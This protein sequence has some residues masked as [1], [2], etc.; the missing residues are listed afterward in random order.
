MEAWMDK[1]SPRARCPEK[2]QQVGAQLRVCDLGKLHFAS[3]AGRP[4]GSPSFWTACF[5]R[6]EYANSRPASMLLLVEYLWK[7]CAYF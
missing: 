4:E 1:H 3:A 2:G 6:G 7:N 5:Q